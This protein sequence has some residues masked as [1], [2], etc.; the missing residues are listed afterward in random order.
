MS[1]FN[2]KS[3]YHQVDIAPVCQTFPG[4]SWVYQGKLRHL[5]FTVFP[6]DLSSAPCIFTK[7][8][9]PLEHR[10][11][12]NIVEGEISIPERQNIRSRSYF[13]TYFW[14]VTCYDS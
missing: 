3:E 14:S 12:W 10:I 1:N 11:I 2:L 6:F 13:I 8:F 7:L 5:F 9:E 4:F